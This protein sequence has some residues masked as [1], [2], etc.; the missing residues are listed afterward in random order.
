MLTS[1]LENPTGDKIEIF[2]ADDHD[3]IRRGLKPILRARNYS[4]IG[5]A[6][7]LESLLDQ[8]PDHPD[9]VFIIDLNMGDTKG[10][11]TVKEALNV[12]PNIKIIVYSIRESESIIQEAYNA[13]ALSYIPKSYAPKYL[14]KAIEFIVDAD[15]SIKEK[16][17]KGEP[18][19]NISKAYYIEEILKKIAIK[20]T[21]GGISVDPRGV[22]T[23]DELDIMIKRV[24][25]NS[26]ADIARVKGVSSKSITYKLSKIRSKLNVPDQAGMVRVAFEFE[27]IN[28]PL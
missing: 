9:A 13:G 2:L 20:G 10:V 12:N 6:N 14:V 27:L 16:K 5:E 18:T 8:I 23:T 1:K 4:V 22:L 3:V 15:R 28:I 17:E 25:G 11:Q 26:I 24:L 19:E 7:N 21:A